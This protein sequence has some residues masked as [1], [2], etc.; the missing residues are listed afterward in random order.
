M[1]LAT[2]ALPCLTMRLHNPNH[3]L[4]SEVAAFHVLAP[5]LSQNELQ[6]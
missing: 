6:I 2:M 5:I 4:F 1:A 3:M